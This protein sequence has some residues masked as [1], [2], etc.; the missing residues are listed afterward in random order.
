[1]AALIGLLV[2]V[3]VGFARPARL[4]ANRRSLIALA[5]VVLGGLVW[6]ILGLSEQDEYYGDDTTVWDHSRRSGA[7]VLV[8]VGVAAAAASIVG[9]VWAASSSGS[10]PRSAVLPLTAVACLLLLYGAFSAGVGH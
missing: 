1:M 2:V 3:V 6:V 9:L 10:R 7:W 8:I 5:A 4:L